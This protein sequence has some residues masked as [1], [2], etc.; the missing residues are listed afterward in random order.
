MNGLQ[1]GLL[2]VSAFCA[3]YSLRDG[4]ILLAYTTVLVVAI[5]F[6]RVFL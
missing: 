5:A 1:V 4:R 6:G 3:G 2:L